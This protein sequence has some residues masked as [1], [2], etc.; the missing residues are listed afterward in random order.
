[1]KMV[2]RKIYRSEKPFW[3]RGNEFRSSVASKLAIF[4]FGTFCGARMFGINEGN[5]Y[6]GHL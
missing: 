2:N 5:T 3:H 6:G 1:M 4:S